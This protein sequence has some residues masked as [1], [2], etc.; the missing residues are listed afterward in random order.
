MID[1]LAT[2]DMTPTLAEL[3]ADSPPSITLID[4]MPSRL[5]PGAP[6]KSAAAGVSKGNAVFDIFAPTSISRHSRRE[7]DAGT[8]LPNQTSRAQQVEE[9]GA[10]DSLVTHTVRQRTRLL[11]MRY[12]TGASAELDAR[13]EILNARTGKLVPRVDSQVWSALDSAEKLFSGAEGEIERLMSSL[14]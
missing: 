1:A 9:S 2:Y 5:T 11:A 6:S 4:D 7:P 10:V 3:L 8:A 14:R 12:A 13:L